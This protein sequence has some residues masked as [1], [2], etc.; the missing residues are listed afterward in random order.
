[1]KDMIVG[2]EFQ[3][4]ETAREWTR[5]LTFVVDEVRGLGRDLLC[6]LDKTY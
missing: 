6:T 2:Q 5:G 3:L 1:M 4:N